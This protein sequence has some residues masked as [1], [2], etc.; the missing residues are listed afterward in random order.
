MQYEN[1]TIEH[2][3]LNTLLLFGSLY[4]HTM[5]VIVQGHPM[6][7]CKYFP[8]PRENDCKKNAPT[9]ISSFFEEAV[10]KTIKT[11]VTDNKVL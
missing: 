8:F 5:A 7:I 9:W 1:R 4:W 11:H 10:G 3:Q 2:S 6:D